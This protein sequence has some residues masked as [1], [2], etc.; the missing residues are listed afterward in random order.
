MV[1]MEIERELQCNCTN[2]L[3][4]HPRLIQKSGMAY[5]VRAKNQQMNNSWKKGHQEQDLDEPTL[6]ECS[7]VVTD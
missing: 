7:K 2:D 3:L 4:L 1:L 5:R 6:S